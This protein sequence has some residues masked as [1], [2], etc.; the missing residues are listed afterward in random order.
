MVCLEA[1]GLLLGGA[2]NLIRP[3]LI[4]VSTHHQRTGLHIVFLFAVGPLWLGTSQTI[5]RHLQ[6]KDFSLIHGNKRFVL[7]DATHMP[8]KGKL[9]FLWVLLVPARWNGQRYFNWIILMFHVLNVSPLNPNYSAHIPGFG[10]HILDFIRC[11]GLWMW[12]S[13]AKPWRGLELWEKRSIGNNI[14]WNIISILSTTSEVFGIAVG[15]W[16]IFPR[17]KS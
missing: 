2:A 4:F 13:F 1:W 10:E 15:A 17:S 9:R 12:S 8:M 3:D 5:S 7:R 16:L 11:A 6:V 14:I